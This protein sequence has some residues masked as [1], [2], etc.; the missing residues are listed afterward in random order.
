VL[1]VPSVRVSEPVS[2][3]RL[4]VTV[5]AAAAAADE[6]SVPAGPL[7]L[8]VSPKSGSI[9][10]LAVALK[11]LPAGSDTASAALTVPS[12]QLSRLAVGAVAGY[13]YRRVEGAVGQDG[14]RRL[15]NPHD[16]VRIEIRC[17]Q[18]AAPCTFGEPRARVARGC[19]PHGLRY[20]QAVTMFQPMRP[21]VR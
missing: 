11:L 4:P 12:A 13:R 19:L 9:A 5:N 8:A 14:G 7:T 21:P 1:K 18:R 20:R 6:P 15:D 10:A 2:S 17:N 3:S 16:F